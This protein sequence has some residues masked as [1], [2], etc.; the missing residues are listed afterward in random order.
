[1]IPLLFETAAQ[2][3]FTTTICVACSAAAQEQRLLRRGWS[4]DQIDQRIKAQWPIDKKM[5][6]ADF[7]VWTDG[8]LDTHARQCQRILQALSVAV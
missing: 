1:M 3:H 8:D 5:L 2:S 4:P 6:L 7:V